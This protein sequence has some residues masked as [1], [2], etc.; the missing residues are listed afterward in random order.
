MDSLSFFFFFFFFFGGV[1]HKSSYYLSFSVEF[2]AI[3]ANTNAAFLPQQPV[4]A[5]IMD[6][7]MVS[8]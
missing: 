1:C 3:D 2:P 4:A 6:I 8:G 7:N 5:W